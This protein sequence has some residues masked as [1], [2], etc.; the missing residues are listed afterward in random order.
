MRQERAAPTANLNGA[1]GRKG[2]PA[3]AQA[4]AMAR[5]RRHTMQRIVAVALGLLAGLGAVRDPAAAQTDCDPVYGCPTTSTTEAETE[6]ELELGDDD[7]EVGSRVGVQACGYAPGDAGRAGT[8]TFAGAEVAD[9][10]LGADGCLAEGEPFDGYPES[11]N[12]PDRPPGGYDVCAVFAGYPAPC[13]RFRVVSEEDE[14]RDGGD[15]EEDADGA[16]ESGDGTEVLGIER[17]RGG[18][19]APAGSASGRGSSSLARTGATIGALV[20]GLVALAFMLSTRTMRRSAT[21]R[22]GPRAGQ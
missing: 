4:D 6:P 7:G 14:D 3:L 2:T 12:V 17:T 22:E 11:F 9:V 13:E 1:N 18:G 19:E 10:T 15:T 21:D 8:I 16:G 5:P 20:A